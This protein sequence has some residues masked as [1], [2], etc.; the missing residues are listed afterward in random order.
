MR[1]ATQNYNMMRIGYIAGGLYPHRTGGM[2][3]FDYYTI[4]ELSKE[5]QLSVYSVDSYN[6]NANVVSKAIS[7]RIVFKRGFRIGTLVY[8]LR[9]CLDVLKSRNKCDVFHISITCNCRNYALIFPYF[10]SLIG[11]PYVLMIHGGGM[12]QW[13]PIS[14]YRRLFDRATHVIAVSDLMKDEYMRRYSRDIVKLAPLL[15]PNR[16]LTEKCEAR[17]QLHLSLSSIVILYVGSLK[18]IKNP[19]LLTNAL[20]ILGAEFLQE[21]EVEVLVVGSGPE[22]DDLE[23]FCARNCLSSFVHFCGL[24][25]H[26]EV[27]HY[28]SAS[29]IF[30]ITSRYEGNSMSMIDAI[31]YQLPIIG[32]N[33]PGICNII[34]NNESGLL[35]DPDDHKAFADSIKALVRHDVLR[36]EFVNQATKSIAPLYDY[37]TNI[38][39]MINLYK[40]AVS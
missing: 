29:D 16:D 30:V 20:N 6:G 27:G 14:L 9:I 22:R 40:S 18:K 15:P 34:V 3:I 5:F 39:K 19:E 21:N 13:K 36:L 11:R 35:V 25:K 38:Q 32:T 8:A 28:Y 17:R 33:V 10:F 4:H 37:N 23:E 26:E 31:N 24:V 2:E 1:E 12:K 7:T